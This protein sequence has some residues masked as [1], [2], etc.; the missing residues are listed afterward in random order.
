MGVSDSAAID[1]SA[2]LFQQVVTRCRAGERVGLCTVVATKGST[3]QGAGAKMMITADGRTLGTLGGGCVEAEVRRAA[4]ALL[5][6]PSGQSTAMRFSLDRD[7][8]WDDGLICGGVMDIHVAVVD[9][10]EPFEPIAAAVAAERSTVYQFPYTLGEN[11]R[12]YREEIGPPADA[13]DHRGGARGAGAGDAGGRLGVP[14]RRA[15]RPGGPP[16]GRSVP[17]RPP[18]DR[19]RDRHAP[20]GVPD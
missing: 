13:A 9:D 3:P 18:A 15:R 17:A 5:A 2:G 11:T 7:Y 12:T 16:D 6:D 1:P 4:G 19:R 10:P 20:A 14:G 8:G